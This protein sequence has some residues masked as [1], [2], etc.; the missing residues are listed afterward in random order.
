MSIVIHAKEILAYCGGGIQDVYIV[1]ANNQL[2]E[3]I[4]TKDYADDGSADSYHSDVWLPIK[5]SSGKLLHV[6]EGDLDKVFDYN[7][8]ELQ[9]VSVPKEL[10]VNKPEIVV[11]KEIQ[12]ESLLDKKGQPI[13]NADGSYQVRSR[14]KSTKYFRWDGTKLVKVK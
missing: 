11:F 1:D 12:T 13:V 8:G 3:L 6:F 2:S 7:S 5:F 4:R 14:R 9:I 10:P